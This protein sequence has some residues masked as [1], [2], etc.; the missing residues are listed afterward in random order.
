MAKK[1][2]N[3][4]FVFFEWLTRIT[5]KFSY[6]HLPLTLTTHVM[7]HANWHNGMKKTSLLKNFSLKALVFLPY[8]VALASEATSEAFSSFLLLGFAFASCCCF[9]P[10]VDILG[11]LIFYRLLI[12]V[13]PRRLWS[14]SAVWRSGEARK[15]GSAQGVGF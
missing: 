3:T 11:V 6:F 13:R 14:S 9:I 15:D 5:G 12:T 2:L 4:I 10:W 8:S 1:H 7:S